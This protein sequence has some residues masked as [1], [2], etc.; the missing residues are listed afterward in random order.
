MLFYSNEK[1]EDRI[2]SFSTFW[3]T[4]INHHNDRRESKVS[5]VKWSVNVRMAFK[6]RS[7]SDLWT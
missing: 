2:S 3:F 6:N 1:K 4:F 7:D 5:S